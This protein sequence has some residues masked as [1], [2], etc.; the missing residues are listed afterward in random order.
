MCEF[1]LVCIHRR[2]AMPVSSVP[3]QIEKSVYPT[4]LP[5]WHGEW[6]LRWLRWSWL[7]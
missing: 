1:M 2:F 3:V 7:L 6:L 5:L 4:V